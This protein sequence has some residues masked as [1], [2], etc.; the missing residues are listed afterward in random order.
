MIAEQETH[1]LDGFP[2]RLSWVASSSLVGPFVNPL[3][4]NDD[5]D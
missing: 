5:F 3:P 4:L 1:H 2:K